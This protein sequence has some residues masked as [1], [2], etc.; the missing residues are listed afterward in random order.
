MAVDTTRVAARPRSLREVHGEW[1]VF[2]PLDTESLHHE[3]SCTISQVQLDEET[4]KRLLVIELRPRKGRVT[5]S[6]LLPSGLMREPGVVLQFEESEPGPARQIQTALP[7]GVLVDL[8]FDEAMT[9]L[10]MSS[11]RLHVMATADTGEEVNF[12]I[13]LSGFSSAL[14]RARHHQACSHSI[15]K[16][17]RFP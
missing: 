3:A 6:L 9:V 10:L 13:P 4:R 11:H 7:N 5:G 2:A 14:A 1:T 12:S 17:R 16:D 15:K 8:D